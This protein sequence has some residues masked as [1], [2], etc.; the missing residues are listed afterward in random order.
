M[1]LDY[2][3]LIQPISGTKFQILRPAQ[4]Y[5]LN[6]YTVNTHKLHDLAVELPT[7]AGKT[8]LALLILDYWRRSEGKRGAFLT[9]NKLL[10]RQVEQEANELNVPVVRFEGSGPSLAAGDLRQY[11]RCHAIGVMNYWVYIN[12]K[13]SVEP[14]DYLVLDDAQLAEGA[15]GSLY[16]IRIDRSGHEELFTDLMGLFGQYTDSP[17]VEDVLKGL[18]DPLMTSADLICFPDLIRMKD[19]I[20][21]LVS[22]YLSS[23]AGSGAVDLR[24]RWDRNRARIAQTLCW[25]SIHDIVFRPYIYP[26]QEYAHLSSAEQRLYMS[27]TIHD[28]EDLQ[29]RLGS[30]LI[31][32]LIV[33]AGLIKED[34]GR[35]LFVFNQVVGP[36]YRKEMPREALE[37]LGQ[38]LQH[39]G[40]S[41]WL[42]TSAHEVGKWRDWLVEYFTVNGQPDTQM[43]VLTPTGDELQHFQLSTSGHL[44][45][46][47]RFEGMD[48][49]DDVCRLAV[50][51][52]LPRA[53][54]TMEQFFSDH[55]RDAS[56]IRNRTLERVKQGIGRCVRGHDDYAV[57]Y[58]LDPRFYLEMESA[59]FG[60]LIGER[61]RKHVELG[62][63]LTED[64]MGQVVPLA[65]KFL[66]GDFLEFDRLEEAAQ[67]PTSSDTPDGGRVAS[68]ADYEVAG[69]RALYSSRDFESASTTFNEVCQLLQD[70]EREH[71]AFWRYNQ[72]HAEY[73]RHWMDET[74]A[75]I[76]RAVRILEEATSEGGLSSWFNRLTRAKNRLARE[77]ED[78]LHHDLSRVFD[79]WDPF[80]ERY[81]YR[82]GR[83]MKWQA[84][85]KASIDGT[86]DQI[87]EAL[88]VLGTLLGFSASRP[89][90]PGA[91]DNVWKSPDHVLTIEIKSMQERNSVSLADVNQANGQRETAIA[92]FR[93]SDDQVNGLI[94]TQM[95]KIDVVADKARGL[96]RCLPLVLVDELRAR[97]ESVMRDYWQRWDAS[98]APARSEARRQAGTRLPPP[99]WLNRVIRSSTAPFISASE[100]FTEWRI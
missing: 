57:C 18:D 9:G 100:L 95:D 12:Q 61:T 73:L 65:S 5:I 40:K 99:G 69:W 11:R 43:W 7:G 22:H 34:E 26:F 67:P 54:G 77:E 82:R 30:P 13:P 46:A 38:L 20:E 58:F 17:V 90:I 80:V 23:D 74:P 29:R 31:Q 24:F 92:E 8:L 19:E 25:V 83:F 93:F 87:A 33:P 75:A 14:A 21:A 59:E 60:G 3:S 84:A 48:F 63:S 71:R 88:E 50:F 49:P 76:T 53:V 78:E 96:I 44:F 81:P 36:S 51:P 68:T 27:A 62:L 4:E 89:T 97:M 56:F 15:L 79:S 28:P 32:K 6:E 70:A 72:A 39:T 16:T 98:D 94:I 37:P 47:G 2:K 35:S 64:G 85:L 66:R 41:I 1:P 91:A 10:A 42:C 45:V 52:S 55:L 86:H